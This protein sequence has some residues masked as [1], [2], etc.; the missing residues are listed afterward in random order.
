M[1]VVAAKT[2]GRGARDTFATPSKLQPFEKGESGLTGIFGLAAVDTSRRSPEQTA[3]QYRQLNLDLPLSSTPSSTPSSAESASQP[4]LSRRTKHAKSS[5]TSEWKCEGVE[6]MVLASGQCEAQSP[7]PNVAAADRT[8]GADKPK[9]IQARLVLLG[10]A[11]VGKTSLILRFVNN[12]FEEN[13]EPTIGAAFLKQTCKLD[14]QIVQFGIC[15]TAGHEMFRNFCFLYYQKAHA[16][17]VC[18]DITKPASL[19]EAKSWVK[20]LKRQANPNIVI[21]LVGTKLDLARAQRTLRQSPRVVST[22]EAQQYANEAGL[23]FMETS[24]KWGDDVVPILRQIVQK[25]PHESVVVPPVPLATMTELDRVKLQRSHATSTYLPIVFS[26]LKAASD[27]EPFITLVD[28]LIQF[29]R[30]L[31]SMVQAKEKENHESS[32]EIIVLQGQLLSMQSKHKSELESIEGKHRM[33]TN[34]LKATIESLTRENDN[35]TLKVRLGKEDNVTLIA[36]I[37]KLEG[38]NT[39]VMLER[40]KRKVSIGKSPTA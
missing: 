22:E 29:R 34:E 15:D 8:D 28:E 4:S 38:E 1:R 3:E 2:D 16:A 9:P 20:E 31:E 14:E 6:E 37:K 19:V 10:G 23:L 40:K 24:A 33:E 27:R 30:G 25:I 18:Y 32:R 5:P 13:K 39:V 11:A 26:V 7:D 35:L 17:M 12:E 36:K 21:A